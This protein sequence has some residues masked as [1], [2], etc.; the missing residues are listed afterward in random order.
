MGKQS[1]IHHPAAKRAGVGVIRA[2][3]ILGASDLGSV[4]DSSITNGALGSL[5]SALG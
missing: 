2:G 4:M 5:A 1:E 3:V